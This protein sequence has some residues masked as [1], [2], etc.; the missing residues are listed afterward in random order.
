MNTKIDKI[1]KIDINLSNKIDFYVFEV[2]QSFDAIR[3]YLLSIEED[4]QK[5]KFSRITSISTLIELLDK[6]KI[7]TIDVTY[8]EE[9]IFQIEKSLAEY[10]KIYFNDYFSILKNYISTSNKDNNYILNVNKD[11]FLYD[12]LNVEELNYLS[13]K[14]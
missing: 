9:T 6:F 1:F 12:K 8:Q 7:K 11:D 14:K 3:Y 13:K 10:E 5:F 2:K 4:N